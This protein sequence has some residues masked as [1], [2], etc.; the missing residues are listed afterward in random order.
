MR[1]SSSWLTSGA[2][3]R[4]G[5]HPFW[6]F[7]PPPVGGEVAAL[8]RAGGVGENS[9]SLFRS[10]TPTPALPRKRGARERGAGPPAPIPSFANLLTTLRRRLS[11]VAA[12][13]DVP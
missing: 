13:T 3:P 9:N 8:E 11:P 10:G 4:G 12:R 2:C 5:P 1:R 6:F 7:F